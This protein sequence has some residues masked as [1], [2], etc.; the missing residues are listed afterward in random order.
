MHSDLDYMDCYRVFTWN[1]KDYSDPAGTIRE[2]ADQGY[3]AFCVIDPGVTFD[4]GY[5]KYDKGIAGD[6]LAKTP[7]REVYVNAVWPGDSVYPDYG[8]PKVRKLCAEYQKYLTDIGVDGV[9]NDLNEPA[10]LHGELPSDVVYT[11]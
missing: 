4:P 9:W 8:Q 5:H 3:K 1:E 7:E 2:L 11:D 10:N 6:Y